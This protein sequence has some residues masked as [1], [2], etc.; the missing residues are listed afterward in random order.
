[1]PEALN[2]DSYTTSPLIRVTISPLFGG[3]VLLF[4][5]K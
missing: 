3:H 2:I 4:N 5:E 1:M